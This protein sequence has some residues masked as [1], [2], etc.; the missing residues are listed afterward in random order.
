MRSLFSFGA[1]KE[2]SNPPVMAAGRPEILRRKTLGANGRNITLASC[3]CLPVALYALV[4]L[5][6]VLPFLLAIIGLAVGIVTVALH[7]RGQFEAAAASQVY[8]VVALGV[9][10]AIADPAIVD[11][12]LATALLAPVLASLVGENPMRKRSWTLVVGVVA[13]AC[14]SYLHW[15]SWPQIAVRDFSLNGAVA[16]AIIALIVSDTAARLGSAFEVYDSAQ[17]N[18]YRHLIEHVQD[19]VMRFSGDGTLLFAS[20]S[21]ETLFGCQRY[22][23]TGNGIGERLHVLDRPT[24]FTAFS[25]ANRDGRTRLIEVRMR[26]DDA[27]AR[28]PQ[29]LWVEVSLSPVIENDMPEE[30]H[31]VVAL[32]RDIT[33]RKDHEQEMRD[34]RRV[35]EDASNAKSRFLAMIGHEL[36]TPLNAI[37]GFSEMMTT[38]IGGELSPSHQEYAAMIHQSGHHLL[39]VVKMLLDMSKIEAGK[40]EL[41]T[42]PFAPEALVEPSLKI[43]ESMARTRKLTIETD[44]AAHLPQ[45]VADERACRQIL[46]NLLSNAIKFSRDEGIVRLSMKR[47]GQNL[48]ISVHDD[49]I[50]MSA[51]SVMR[52]GEPFFQ[53]QDGLSRRYEGTGLGLSIV[54]GLVDLHEGSLHASSEMGV[55]TTMTVLLPVNG[56]ALKLDEPA[57]I[58]PIRREAEP[59]LIPSWQDAKRKAL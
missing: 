32:F 21:T 25:D 16:F 23:L 22:E 47:Q 44:I 52:L 53:A 7:Q 17:I 43:V 14:A 31:E 1:S 6:V 26:R 33:D 24:Y 38:G 45:L 56:P 20:R 39:D 41:Q 59:V 3:I 4:T 46:I 57:E 19:A 13:L 48:N 30:R 12:G 50:G 40:F 8:G 2:T 36:R 37:V 5:G 49:G 35:A 15:I 55:G 42:E 18:A 29:F 10:P 51:E 34:A 9:I 11:F 27:D 54:K 28:T 58:T